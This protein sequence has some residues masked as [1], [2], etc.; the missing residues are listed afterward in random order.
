MKGIDDTTPDPRDLAQ[1]SLSKY[2]LS[3]RVIAGILDVDMDFASLKISASSQEDDIYVV[4]DN[5]RHNYGNVHSEGPLAG[6]HYKIEKFSPEESLV[7]NTKVELN[8]R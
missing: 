4:R 1:D 3:S 6:L 2:D 5:D 8:L 7:E